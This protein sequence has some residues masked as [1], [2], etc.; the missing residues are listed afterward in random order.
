MVMH[1]LVNASLLNSA[2]T[3]QSNVYRIHRLG[4]LLWVIE[5]VF[6]FLPLIFHAVLGLLIIRGGSPNVGDYPF[7]ANVRYT[8]QRV[9]SIIAL[10]FIG[11]HVFHMHGWLHFEGW[12]ETV[13]DPLFGSQFRPFN[14]ATSVALGMKPLVVPILYAVGILACVLHLANGIWTMGITWGVWTSPRAQQRA[15]RI[16][17]AV[18][19]VVAVIGAAALWGTQTVAR[20]LEDLQKVWKTEQ[21]MMEAMLEHE[22]VKEMIKQQSEHKGWTKEELE[23]RW[24]RLERE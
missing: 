2:A 16:C 19:L 5:W 6:I 11:W 24:S 1:L 23:A 13:A 4:G 15:N 12:V 8:M 17:V 10:L 3:F 22:E 20:D 21:Q 14:A 18:G 7:A 9:T